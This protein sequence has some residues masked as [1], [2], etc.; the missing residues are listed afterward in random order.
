[1]TFTTILSNTSTTPRMNRTCVGC[2]CARIE[3]ISEGV[4]L[5]VGADG[6][7]EMGELLTFKIVLYS[8][9]C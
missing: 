8:G 6:L 9:M 2:V 5:V 1:M 4:K 7:G 3:N